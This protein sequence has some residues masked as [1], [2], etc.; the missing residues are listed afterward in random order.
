MPSVQ[1]GGR[2]DHYSVE[3]LI[4]RTDTASIYRGEAH[5][6][7]P[8][9]RQAYDR[10]QRCSRQVAALDCGVTSLNY[11]LSVLLFRAEEPR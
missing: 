7:G 8:G 9:A 4:A 5:R 3:D 1:T 11:D 6:I 10:S 2:L